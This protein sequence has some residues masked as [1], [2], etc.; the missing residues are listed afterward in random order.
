VAN[1]RTDLR[2]LLLSGAF[3]AD[4]QLKRLAADT[5][6][7]S[8]I[9]DAKRKYAKEI[10]AL[11]AK[12]VA[13]QRVVATTQAEDDEVTI[14]VS[15]MV[16]P[17]FPTHSACIER[18]NSILA[19]ADDMTP[20]S[21]VAEL[22][23]ARAA[24]VKSN[25]GYHDKCGCGACVSKRPRVYSVEEQHQIERDLILGYDVPEII[26]AIKELVPGWMQ[27]DDIDFTDEGTAVVLKK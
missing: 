16:T 3:R 27:G 7:D 12:P 19:T 17:S 5:S 18:V 11:T 24:H 21:L 9:L 23:S 20:S 14:F 13:A 8:V 10:R 4:R 15:G 25:S 26:A 22:E 2:I 6:N 1:R